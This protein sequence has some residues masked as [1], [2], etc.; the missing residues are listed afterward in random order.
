MPGA[1]HQ[2]MGVV[3]PIERS[4]PDPSTSRSRAGPSWTSWRVAPDPRP[5]LLPRLRA[6]V[7]LPSQF[8]ARPGTPQSHSGM[9]HERGLLRAGARRASA[10][11]WSRWRPSAWPRGRALPVRHGSPARIE[12]HLARPPPAAARR[13][14]AAIPRSASRSSSAQAHGRR[15]PA[16]PREPG[17]AGEGAT[18][19]L[20]AAN[21]RL[22]A[23]IGERRSAEEGSRLREPLHPRLPAE[24]P[25]P[26]RSPPSTKADT[27]T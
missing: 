23:E 14:L 22:R 20:E 4:P 11:P 17:V 15:A 8:L 21:A 26:S 7:Q 10:S 19:D 1:F 3:D 13:G 12:E 16:V 25:S 9:H 24:L 2:K 6:P 18:A 27:S 5:G